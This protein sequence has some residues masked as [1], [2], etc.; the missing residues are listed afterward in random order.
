MSE[1]NG[2]AEFK[3]SPVGSSK[4]RKQSAENIQSGS[5]KSFEKKIASGI[6]LPDSSVGAQVPGNPL[7]ALLDRIES[8]GLVSRAS[9]EALRASPSSPFALRD[10]LQEWLQCEQDGKR[11]R[12]APDLQCLKPDA[13]LYPTATQT[14]FKLHNLVLMLGQE[15]PEMK[16]YLVRS[17]K[18]GFDLEIKGERKRAKQTFNYPQQNAE[19]EMALQLSLDDDTALGYI[20]EA[21]GNEANL[22]L[23]SVFCVP[24]KE[25]GEPIPNKY[26]R[27]VHP[28]EANLDTGKESS[29][30]TYSTVLEAAQAAV[31]LRNETKKAVRFSKYDCKHAF[32]LLPLKTDQ[33]PLLGFQWKG[34]KYLYGRVAFGTRC[35]SRLFSS[36]SLTVNWLLKH[37]FLCPIT[38]TYCDDFSLIAADDEQSEILASVFE[39]VMQLLGIPL[40]KEKSLV[41]MAKITFLGIEMDAEFETLALPEK[42]KQS[43]KRLLQKWADSAQMTVHELRSLTGV[44]TFVCRTCAPGKLFL[45]RLYNSVAYCDARE[46]PEN[47]LIDIG[48]EMKKD[49]RWWQMVAPHL[50]SMSMRVID[51]PFTIIVHT[52]AS[53]FGGAEFCRNP[54]D[55]H[56]EYF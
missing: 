37:V 44:L 55:A 49:I 26:R 3:N 43:L 20:Y 30:M 2:A 29:A 21:T 42:R 25:F 13:S 50:K 48:K 35:G 23:N 15:L 12:E 45:R 7:L 9:A 39:L 53:D 6:P 41:G 16:E 38:F 46:L 1:G 11:S 19:E 52:D 33:Q 40:Q 56:E 32:H 4:K 18:F 22:L 24:K 36:V 17:F 10:A 47:W 8:E 28:K 27:V 5:E 31:A 14:S 34:K 54:N 51:L